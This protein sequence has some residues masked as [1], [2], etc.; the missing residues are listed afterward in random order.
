MPVAEIGQQREADLRI[1]IGEE[2]DFQFIDQIDGVR[3]AAEQGR[4]RDQRLRQWRNAAAE[5]HSW[6]R[7]RGDGQRRNLVDQGDCELAERDDRAARGSQPRPIR[8]ACVPQLNQRRRGQQ[9]T[10]QE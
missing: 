5:I 6:Q 8:I 10:H 2:A 1:A 3:F 7:L 4:H 9:T